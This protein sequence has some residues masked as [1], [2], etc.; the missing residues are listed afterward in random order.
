[1]LGLSLL[2]VTSREKVAYIWK[3]TQKWQVDYTT[4]Q[5]LNQVYSGEC[6]LLCNQAPCLADRIQVNVAHLACNILPAK[7]E[8]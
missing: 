2:E 6:I 7:L 4:C 1:M 8:Y 5:H 3:Y